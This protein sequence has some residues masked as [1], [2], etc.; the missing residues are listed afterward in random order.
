MKDNIVEVVFD[1]INTDK[2]QDLEEVTV[3]NKQK[4]L[5]MGII[6][7]ELE[8]IERGESLT[9]YDRVSYLMGLDWELELVREELSPYSYDDM[10]E[11]LKDYG[12]PYDIEGEYSIVVQGVPDIHIGRSSFYSEY[13]EE[14]Y[15]QLD[16]VQWF[17][18]KHL[19]ST[20]FVLI[21]GV[22]DE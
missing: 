21:G 14:P 19:P 5:E 20:S 6:I 18:I 13:E 11:A 2:Y 4:E 3:Y 8:A 17:I 10:V 7:N 22:N 9:A 15:V 12:I 1:V 16:V